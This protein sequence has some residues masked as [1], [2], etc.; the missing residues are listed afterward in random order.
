VPGYEAVTW[1]GLFAPAGT[2]REIIGRLHAEVQRIFADTNFQEKF[3][4]P[5]MF[6]PMTGSPEE[7]TAFIKSESQ[8][9]S[10]VV[11]DSNLKIE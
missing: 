11:R 4:V 10:K 2:S 8:K 3:I 6:Q 7:F 1:F 9:W 5:Q